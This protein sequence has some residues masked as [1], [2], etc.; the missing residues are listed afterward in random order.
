MALPSLPKF[1]H[2]F[3]VF[4]KVLVIIW[5]LELILRG[6]FAVWQREFLVQSE[7]SDILAAFYIGIRFDGRIA[8]ILALPLLVFIISPFDRIKPAYIAL[9][10]VLIPALLL[11]YMGDFA[12]YAY[13]STRINYSVFSE[14]KDIKEAAGVVWSSYPVIPL[15][16]LLILIGTIVYFTFKRALFKKEAVRATGNRLKD[17]IFSFTAALFFS[18]LLIYGQYAP[19]AFPLRWSEA[20]FSGKPEITALALNPAQNIYDTKPKTNISAYDM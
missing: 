6:A 16:G 11:I 17:T 10:T 5:G 20:Y 15:T 9:Y 12:H 8:A 18:A 13:M 2:N 1:T 4:L 14:M 7:F 3:F 19:N